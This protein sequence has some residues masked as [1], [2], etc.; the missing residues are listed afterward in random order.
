MKRGEKG[1]EKDGDAFVGSALPLGRR[2]TTTAP[3]CASGVSFDVAL[4]ETMRASA[5]AINEG[6]RSF[7]WA[8][9]TSDASPVFCRGGKGGT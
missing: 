8:I 7:S 9:A 5:L 6:M 3:F 2:T 4:D 1:E